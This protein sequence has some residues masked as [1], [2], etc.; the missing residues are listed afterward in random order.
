MKQKKEEVD[1]NIGILN[2]FLRVGHEE[3]MMTT[4][5]IVAQTVRK[6]EQVSQREELEHM[7][8]A[9]KTSAGQE[10]EVYLKLEEARGGAEETE[11]YVQKEYTQMIYQSF[12]NDIFVQ[13]R[14]SSEID[15][16]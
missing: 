2:E 16:E 1:Q 11:G 4:E 14:N 7:Y 9:G 5:D 12:F 8:D 15:S 6:A 3:V 13:M 10:F